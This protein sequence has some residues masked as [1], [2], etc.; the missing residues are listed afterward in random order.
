MSIFIA[1]KCACGGKLEFEPSKK[2]WICKYCG[3]IV[4]R[5]ATFDKVHVDGIEGI[6]DVVRQ[7]LMDITNRKMES[8]SRNLA[9][10]ERKGQKH[11]GT[12]LANLSYNLGM[13]SEAKGDE[14]KAYIDKIKMYAKR[15]KQEF[16]SIT[17]DEINLYENFGSNADDIFANLV[18]LFDTISEQGRAEYVLSKLNP[19]NVFSTY[20]NK[21]LLKVS[22]NQHEYDRVDKI[23]KN[24]GHI[25]RDYSLRMIMENYPDND[26][27]IVLIKTLFSK[28][29][30]NKLTK[31]F[32]EE[33]FTNINDN[34][35][36]KA[37]IVRLLNKTDIHV[38]AEKV[39]KNIKGKLNN[40]NQA[41]NLF[42][43]IYEIKIN[44]Q[45]TE[46]ILVFCL[47]MNDNI[48]IQKAFLDSLIDQ[49][50][51]VSLNGRII[52][53]YLDSSQNSCGHKIE[54]LKRVLKFVIDTRT[55]DSVY[56]YYLNNNKDEFNTRKE[57]I[58]LLLIP[59]APLSSATIE[60]YV[61]K[62]ITDGENKLWVVNKIFETGYIKTYVGEILNK[63][64][65]ESADP[66]PIKTKIIDF[67]IGQGFKVDSGM[68]VRYIA[69]P[70]DDTKIK[71]DRIKKLVANGTQI[72]TDSLEAYLISLSSPDE[73]SEEMFN[74]LTSHSYSVSLTTYY[75]YLLFC[76]DIDKARHNSMLLNAVAGNVSD[77]IINIDFQG[78]SI[79]CNLFQAYVLSTTDNI[80]IAET[81]V[82]TFKNH[83]V[84]LNTDIFIEGNAIKFKKFI[85]E[86]KN[87][88]SH[89]S[90]QLCEENRMFS[91]F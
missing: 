45:E 29:V 18:V 28:E 57:I 27:K 74:L 8:A 33:Y 66:E 17:E 49:K 3:T 19:E 1:R 80:D 79:S 47:M 34:V 76:K 11:I 62:T 40:Y 60:N 26:R 4:E 15:L 30:A 10:C 63:Y 54:V 23:V 89:L 13:I 32:F 38:N 88:L 91:I 84:K 50:V 78:T 31:A 90:L 77:S 16:P 46:A 53:S 43:A 24:I 71:Y 2:I 20:A 42:D 25:D 5:E 70:N 7:T 59:K 9:D 72:R 86:V 69:T 39:V 82:D 41:K 52:I 21:S 85:G 51:F 61:V 87:S 36:I 55:L 37:E 65:I 22:L 83:H 75:K 73:F 48:E 81:I 12:L 58:K 44:D 67:L 35:E 64:M 68:L 56:N 6:D 14:Q